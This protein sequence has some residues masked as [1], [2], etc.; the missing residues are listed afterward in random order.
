MTFSN[1]IV[2]MT[3]FY[4]K[5]YNRSMTKVDQIIT[6]KWVLTS[7]EDKPQKN[8]SI[9]LSGNRIH[10]IENSG[11]ILKKYK[12]EKHIKLPNHILLPGLINPY[13]QLSQ[14]LATEIKKKYAERNSTGKRGKFT[15]DSCLNIAA[16]L[17]AIK[18]IK[19]G[20]TSYSNISY[21]PDIFIKTFSQT[22]IKLF[23]GLPILYN[24]NPWSENE[25]D[26]FKKNLAIYDEYKSYP[27]TKMFFCLFKSEP[28][29]QSMLDKI[30]NVAN[31]LELP[32]MLVN[33]STES[34]KKTRHIFESLIE[35]NLI[36]KNFT[37]ID[38]SLDSFVS[39]L[40]EKYD[41]N[42]VLSDLPE[43][44]FSIKRRRNNISTF[45]ENY[46]L[47][48][49]MSLIRNIEQIYLRN[50][51]KSTI[52]KTSNILFKIIN[53]N[54]AKVICNEDNTAELEINKNADMI[55]IDI[56]RSDIIEDDVMKLHF[57]NTNERNMIDNVWIAGK[58]VYKNRKLVTINEH[59]LYD[60]IEHFNGFR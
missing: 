44:L 50:K 33:N 21:Y 35:L 34:S 32:L 46:V 40:I 28:V 25:I 9:V 38:F 16:K 24:K 47:N 2:F 26:C 12:T 15:F 52:S 55:S 7:E 59:I 18:L 54:A 49:D 43:K 45:I 20:T 14:Q 51:Y 57:F 1:T 10:D 29:S 37:C 22:G 19:S 30:A 11:D 60:E 13:S 58:H 27:N 42:L 17:T 56:D 53:K 23:C 5:S 41:I 6:P 31:E 8:L 3:I 39:N 48:R 4:N 36:N